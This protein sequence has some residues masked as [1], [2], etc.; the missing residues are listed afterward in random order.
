[1]NSECSYFLRGVA[2]IFLLF[3]TF[4][5]H[6]VGDYGCCVGFKFYVIQFVDSWHFLWNQ[7]SVQKDF[8]YTYVYMSILSS[9]RLSVYALLFRY[10]I[11]FGFSFVNVEWDG[12]RFSVWH[13]HCL[14]SKHNLW[15]RLAFLQQ[16][17]LS[18]LSKIRYSNVPG[19]VFAIFFCSI[20][21]DSE[22]FSLLFWKYNTV[23]ITMALFC[24]L[25]HKIVMPVVLLLLPRI[26]FALLGLFRFCM[27]LRLLS[28][29]ML[30]ILLVFSFRWH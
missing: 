2:G 8:I 12:F 28:L 4:C 5:L 23:F 25:E 6:S 26:T 3:Y 9:R 16:R 1:M 19:V 17:N 7:H 11:Y 27:I 22:I 18:T 24:N 10:L 14:F 13:V 20:D 15:R 30:K 21:I 29:A